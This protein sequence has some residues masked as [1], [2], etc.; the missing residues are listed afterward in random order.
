LVAD[1]RENTV[2]A[3]PACA[4]DVRRA[5]P[6]YIANLLTP[7]S[8]IPSRSSLRSSSRS[9]CDLVV[10]RTSRKIGD[11]VFSVAAP[12]AWNRL[13]SDLKLLRSTTSFKSKLE[14]FLFYAAYTENTTKMTMECAIGVITGT[15]QVPVITVTVTV[16]TVYKRK[17]TQRLA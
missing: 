8:D 1:H 3:V 5:L 15:L 4:Q 9:N 2:Q 7:A 6:D 14:S 17:K 16:T 11:R 13:P 10:P 12:R